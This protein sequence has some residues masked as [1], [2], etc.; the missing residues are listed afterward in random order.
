[1]KEFFQEFKKFALR[2]N[3]VDLAIGIVVGAS[4]TAVTNSL[5]NNIITPPLSLLTKG[6][7]FEE[8]S[9][10][11][12]STDAAIHYGLFVQ[13]IISFV[14]TAFVL[15]LLVRFINKLTVAARKEQEEGKTPPSQK[16]AELMV[17]EEIRDTLRKE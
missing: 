3:A 2:G 8:L 10:S 7:N 13:A 5:V 12:P 6:I 16:S 14:I 4:F 9:L 15:F 1:M 17:L 11:I